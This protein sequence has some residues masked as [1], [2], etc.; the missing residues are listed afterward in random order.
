MIS[1]FSKIMW[2]SSKA[3]V[4]KEVCVGGGRVGDYERERE[5]EREGGGRMERESTRRMH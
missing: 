2:R 5:R 3:D 1:L 4:A